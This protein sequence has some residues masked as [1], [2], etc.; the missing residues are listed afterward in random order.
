MGQKRNGTAQFFYIDPATLSAL[1]TAMK[2]H[3][4]NKTAVWC[5]AMQFYAASLTELT[6]A[7]RAKIWKK[8]QEQTK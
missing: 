5:I 2:Q 6:P 7:A 4:T 3:G 8:V 1:H